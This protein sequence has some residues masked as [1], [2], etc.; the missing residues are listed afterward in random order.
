[1]FISFIFM[2]IMIQAFLISLKQTN[3]K[4]QCQF[5]RQILAVRFLGTTDSFFRDHPEFWLESVIIGRQHLPC[6]AIIPPCGLPASLT[7]PPSSQGWVTAM[8]NLDDRT[9]PSALVGPTVMQ[10][11]PICHQDGSTKTTGGP[12][13]TNLWSL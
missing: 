5:R 7:F 10:I 3:T 2:N 13:R 9:W 6:C 12:Y 8:V 11:V 1:M 4:T